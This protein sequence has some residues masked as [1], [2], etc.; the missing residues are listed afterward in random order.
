MVAV[1]GEVEF[2][3]VYSIHTGSLDLVVKQCRELAA[4]DGKR[5]RSDP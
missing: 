3:M 4:V 2:G 5:N 1:R